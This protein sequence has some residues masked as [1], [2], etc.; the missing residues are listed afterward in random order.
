[1]K[2]LVVFLVISCIVLMSCAGSSTTHSSAPVP[3]ET[4]TEFL[5][6]VTAETG[7]TVP[8]E[9]S[10][11]YPPST[12][13]ELTAYPLQGFSFYRW[14]IYSGDSAAPQYTRNQNP[15]RFTL[16]NDAII[17]AA[18]RETSKLFYFDIID[19]R[20]GIPAGIA[21]FVAGNYLEGEAIG[22]MVRSDEFERWVVY[23]SDFEVLEIINQ[24]VITFIMPPYDV[25]LAVEYREKG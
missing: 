23:S 17:I 6:N 9:L 10:G 19:P 21:S 7:G 25:I 20:G 16:Q 5:L 11:K 24:N 12:N 2:R 14:I 8:A 1:M 4:A 3:S 13:I 15:A 22:L 18:F